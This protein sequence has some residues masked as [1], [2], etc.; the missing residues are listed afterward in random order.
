MNRLLTP[1]ILFLSLPLSGSAQI[2]NG[3]FEFDVFGSAIS[4]WSGGILMGQPIGS[5]LLPPFNTP[6]PPISITGNCSAGI[7]SGQTLSQTFAGERGSAYTVS[8]WA[9]YM[10][11]GTAGKLLA[12]VRDENGGVLG[13]LEPSL[14][15]GG[16]GSIGYTEF[17]FAVPVLA[18]SESLV[19]EFTNTQSVEL[20]STVSIDAVQLLSTH[21]SASPTLKATRVASGI[22][23]SILKLEWSEPAFGFVLQR[24]QRPDQDWAD[25]ADARVLRQ[26]GKFVTYVSTAP[27]IQ[28]VFYRLV[29]AQ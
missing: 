6:A 10:P 25:V 3:D 18:Q 23:G 20:D 26:D 11:L 28:Q 12:R 1:A 22:D 9:K 21:P 4:G 16:A 5:P 7:H 19:L 8:F 24:S 13:E 17:F 15:S 2:V 27:R 14:L 29:A